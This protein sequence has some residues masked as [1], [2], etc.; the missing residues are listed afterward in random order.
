[1]NPPRA[2]FLDFPLGHTAGKP[3]DPALGRAILLEALDAL[4]TMTAPGSVRRLPFRW[5]E[6]DG[7]KATAMVGGDARLSRDD[8]PQYQNEEDRVRAEGCGPACS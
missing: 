7:W 5:S 6:D 1:M 2:V 8:T 4:E 3:H